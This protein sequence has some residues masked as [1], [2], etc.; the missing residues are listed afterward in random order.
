MKYEDHYQLNK[1]LFIRKWTKSCHCFPYLSKNGK[2]FHNRYD[3]IRAAMD[4]SGVDFVLACMLK[5]EWGVM[6]RKIVVMAWH[7]KWKDKLEH[8]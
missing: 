3:M 2:S 4:V 8:E 1:D 7:A 6:D 5:E